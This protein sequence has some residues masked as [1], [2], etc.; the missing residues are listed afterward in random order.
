MRYL[1]HLVARFFTSLRA[2]R[3]G[4]EDQEFVAAHLEGRLASVFWA[5]PVADLDHALRG[6]RDLAAAHPGRDDLVTAFLL[7]DVGKRRARLGTVRRSLVTLLSILHLPTGA[8]GRA[9][10]E[11]AERGASE[12]VALGAG[13]LSITFAKH[14]HAA[15][16]PGVPESDWD[17]L[18]TADRR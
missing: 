4:P 16:S 1:A 3:P 17:A 5:Q 2:R 12:L 15:V 11:H 13:P 8:R 18:L 9:Y 7:H 6:A 10:L 14:H